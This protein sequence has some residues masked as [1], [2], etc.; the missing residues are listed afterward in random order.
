MD[1]DF[2]KWVSE[3]G[4]CLNRVDKDT[5]REIYE[6][7]DEEDKKPNTIKIETNETDLM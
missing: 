1:D 7:M 6:A 2:E 4:T 3:Q 5:L